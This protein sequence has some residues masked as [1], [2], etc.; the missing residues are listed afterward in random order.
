[1]KNI[2]ISMN[3]LDGIE[4]SGSD[5]RSRELYFDNLI[6]DNN[7]RQGALLGDVD[8]VYFRN[9]HFL[10]AKGG[11][12]AAGA[13]VVQNNPEQAASSLYFFDCEFSGN[14]GGGLLVSP[15]S[16]EPVTLFAQRCRFAPQGNWG[17]HLAAHRNPYVENQ[18]QVP[19]SLIF[20]DCEFQGY[21]DV[22]PVRLNSSM[23][24]VLFMKCLVTEGEEL[25]NPTGRPEASPI[26]F[27]LDMDD[28]TDVFGRT[29]SQEGDVTFDNLVVTG[30]RGR[31]AISFVDRAGHDS[32]HGVRGTILHDGAKIDASSFSYEGPDGRWPEI[33]RFDLST[34]RT[35]AGRVY[36]SSQTNSTLVHVPYS[37]DL[38]AIAQTNPACREVFAGDRQFNLSTLLGVTG[39][40][41]VPARAQ[42]VLK[43]YQG[44]MRVF[45]A[46]GRLVNTLAAGENTTSRY[47][48]IGNPSSGRAEVWSFY[49]PRRARFKF[50]QPLVGIWADSPT[51]LP[52]A[53]ATAVLP[54]PAP[55]AEPSAPPLY[56]D[57]EMA[58]LSNAID[59]L[60]IN[61]LFWA[62]GNRYMDQLESARN[63]VAH[64]RLFATTEQ[65]R[66]NLE[67][68]LQVL[69]RN[70]RLAKTTMLVRT[71]TDTQ[72]LAYAYVDA[73]CH[74]LDLDEGRDAGYAQWRISTANPLET[75]PPGVF[76]AIN[77]P[78]HQGRLQKDLEEVGVEICGGHLTIDSFEQVEQL[79]PAVDLAVRQALPPSSLSR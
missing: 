72:R 68:G 20:Y 10:N 51:N 6:L 76:W 59:R 44:E 21:G 38:A 37:F 19:S 55:P 45:D 42:G 16:Y 63:N 14:G 64:L 25:R 23:L 3:S 65:G 53:D 8:G 30:Y 48:E 56:L 49:I 75:A 27:A 4:I 17:L 69:S 74:L 1:V 58:A 70:E 13:S 77:S 66:K 5:G 36:D 22:S 11:A 2:R 47:L 52:L 9:V 54:P 71:M 67:M 57:P 73:F 34:L 15:S 31:P 60:S 24:S 61:V 7:D 39:Y 50:F 79:L 28:K 46:G 33:A 78:S 12:P 26:L 62:R 29:Y 35:S 40:F 41:E 32:I 18:V 43:L